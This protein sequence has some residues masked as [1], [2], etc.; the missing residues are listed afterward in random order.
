MKKND[1]NA[2]MNKSESELSKLALDLNKEITLGRVK[3]YTEQQKNTR[4]L[5]SVRAKLALVKTALRVKTIGGT[6]E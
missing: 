6:H 3:R 5:R 2:I 4:I 1:R